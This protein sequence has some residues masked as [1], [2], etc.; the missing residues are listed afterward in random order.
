MTLLLVPQPVTSY[1]TVSP[2]LTYPGGVCLIIAVARAAVFTLGWPQ[3]PISGPHGQQ[4]CASGMPTGSTVYGEKGPR[5]KQKMDR[6]PPR[7]QAG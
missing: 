2:V 7:S 6:G 3:S 4:P 5:G 1:K